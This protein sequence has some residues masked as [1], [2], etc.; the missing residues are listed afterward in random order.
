MQNMTQA[1]TQASIESTKAA[2]DARIANGIA[3]MQWP[4]AY[5]Y[6]HT[7]YIY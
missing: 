1:I 3:D 5:M 4:I 6:T 2:L 7:V